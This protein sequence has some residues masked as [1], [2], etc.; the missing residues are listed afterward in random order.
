MTTQTTS[1]ADNGQLRFIAH[2]STVM[3][4]SDPTAS[5][6]FSGTA[7]EASDLSSFN[8]SLRVGMCGKDIDMT[9]QPDLSH[10]FVLS[11]TQMAGDQRKLS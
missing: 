2:L 4:P 10:K 6:I 1:D 9:H 7:S 8:K 11:E 3:L 5:N